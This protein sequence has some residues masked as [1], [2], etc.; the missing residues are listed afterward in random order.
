MQ[1]ESNADPQIMS[2]LSQSEMCSIASRQLYG[3]N[4]LRRSA[5]IHLVVSDSSFGMC[6]EY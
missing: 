2:E 6:V 3:I 5:I 4:Y 1:V